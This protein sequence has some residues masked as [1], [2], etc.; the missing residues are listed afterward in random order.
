MIIQSLDLVNFRNIKEATLAFSG[1]FNVIRGRNAQGKTN[2][3]EAIHLFSL[4]RSF[5]TRRREEM[6][7][8]DEEYLFVR[9]ACT[10]DAGVSF[11]I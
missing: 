2:L 5:R 6:I 4:G 3:L 11:R 7:R 10:S 8:F 1:T 9:L